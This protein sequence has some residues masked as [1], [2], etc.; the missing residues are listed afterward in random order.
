M[1]STTSNRREQL[2]RQQEAAKRQKR[3]NLII[4]LSAGGVALALITVFIVV[5]FQQFSSRTAIAP[6]LVPAAANADETALVVSDSP[7]PEEAPVVTLYLDYQCPNCR[8]FEEFY[9]DMLL[10]E[11]NAGTW[12]LQNTTLLFMEKQLQN[13]ASTRAAVGA[14]CAADLGYYWGYHSEIYQNQEPQ[15]VIGSEGYSD[16]AL[17]ETIPN[18][19]GISGDDLTTFQACYDGQATL[20]FVNAVEKGGYDA[21]IRSTP[22]VAVNG[23]VLDLQGLSENSPAGLKQF[24]LDNA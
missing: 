18:T 13:T 11:A 20:D 10:T 12:T 6:Q 3:L 24:I 17:R 19:I 23:K 15:E 7:A 21:G 2:R 9:G 16:T 22:T 8:Q 4:G 5:M 1:A 14:A